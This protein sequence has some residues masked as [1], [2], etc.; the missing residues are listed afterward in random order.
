MYLI[1]HISLL[2]SFIV[3]TCMIGYLYFKYKKN[4]PICYASRNKK[5]TMNKHSRQ[6]S[7]SFNQLLLL[8]KQQ[9]YKNRIIWLWSNMKPSSLWPLITLTKWQILSERSGDDISWSRELDKI[10][11]A[12]RRSHLNPFNC[13]PLDLNLL[14]LVV[15]M[16]K[17]FD[18]WTITNH[19]I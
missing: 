3:G 5:V 19:W 10:I 11:I 8:T 17:C 14:L 12:T 13:K 7:H 2:S 6:Q 4:F 16:Q 9:S 18:F 1:I 15:S